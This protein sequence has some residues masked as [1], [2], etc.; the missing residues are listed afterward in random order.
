VPFFRDSNARPDVITHPLPALAIGYGSK[1]VKTAL[2]P[3][4]EAVGN[5]D[6]LVLGV[7]RGV[8]TVDDCLRSIDREVAME[9]HHSVSGIDQVRPV[10]LDFVI[11]LSAA[12]RCSKDED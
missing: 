11:V 7:I 6:G 12:K 8:N 3:I 5:L 1:D 2:E 4:V 10:H 9:F